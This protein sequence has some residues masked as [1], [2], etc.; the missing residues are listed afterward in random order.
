ME[1]RASETIRIVGLNRKEHGY[2]LIQER[3]NDFSRTDFEIIVFN[4]VRA[5]DAKDKAPENR[6]YYIDSINSLRERLKKFIK[7]DRVFS[8]VYRDYLRRHNIEYESLL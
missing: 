8:G 1:T 2:D 6:L 4:I 3:G 5:D 7:S